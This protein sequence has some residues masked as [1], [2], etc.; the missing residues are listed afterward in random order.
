MKI[1]INYPS[2]FI[3]CFFMLLACREDDEFINTPPIATDSTLTI[4]LSG[5]V[6]KGPFING[7]AITLSEL[8]EN[9]LATGKNFTSQINDN[10]GAF[11]FKEVPLNS[12]F[13]QLQA[14][15]FYFDEVKGE[16]SSAQLTL[17]GLAH[18][19]DATSV[20]VNL[21]S[22]LEFSRVAYLMQEEESTFE[23]AKQK[24]QSEILT[25]FGIKADSI[26]YSETLDISHDGDDNAI[27][28]VISAILQAD[29]SV[30]EL[31][32]L[33]A[34]IITDL[35]EDGVVNSETTK[36][37]LKEQ[38]MS[39]NLPQI[40]THLEKRY[41]DMGVEATIPNFEQ[42]VDSDGDGILNKDEDDTPENFNFSLQKD[43]ATKVN[44]ISNVVTL[45]GLKEGGTADAIVQHGQIILNGKLMEDSV[46]QVK[47]GDQLQLQLT[48]SDA[49]AD[50]VSTKITIGTLVKNFQVITDDYIPDVFSFTAQKD[51]AVDSF[52]TSNTITVSG[53]P[54]ATPLKIEEGTIIKNGVELETDTTS[55]KNG[56]ELA[57]KLLSSTEFKAA[58]SA[59]VDINGIAASFSITTDDYSPDPFSFTPIKNAKIKRK[60]ISDT[61]TITGLPHPTPSGIAWFSTD[62]HETGAI[63]VNGVNYR[64]NGFSVK[65]GDKI[66]IEVTASEEFSSTLPSSLVIN[67]KEAFFTVTTEQNSWVAKL[68]LSVGAFD[69]RPAAF[70]ID[71][72]VY[73]GTGSADNGVTKAFY[74]YDPATNQ[75]IQRADYGGGAREEG[76]GFAIGNKG[77]IGLGTN[78]TSGNDHEF[79]GYDPNTDTWT[80]LA[81]YP[82][83]I[84]WLSIGF[85]INNKGY[86]GLGG[87]Q[88]DF[89]EYDPETDTWKQ[90]ANLPA[91][92]RYGAIAF[93]MNGKGYVGLG[94][95]DHANL[96]D[97][98]EYDPAIN[99]WKQLSDYP[100][101]LGG[102]VGFSIGNY[103]YIGNN[104]YVDHTDKVQFYQYDP[105][106]D[107]WKQMDIGNMLFSNPIG[108]STSTKGYH[109]RNIYDGV[110]D[111][112]QI[113]EFTP[114]KE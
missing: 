59:L 48:S 107:S 2:L 98:W 71:N 32:E 94:A 46:T 73:F 39:L 22:Y 96:R 106:L 75:L 30:A 20:N 43:V 29:N 65:T 27:L 16:K 109:I 100:G 81:D 113:W 61:I 45:S 85:S 12:P 41:T 24:A 104:Y 64:N 6:Q 91:E 114:P 33:L 93:S 1:F 89:W 54:F 26:G 111:E 62:D 7:T 76:I 99:S 31:S 68:S 28:L 103:A 58:T 35:K 83:K 66:W 70:S 44:I 67:D 36:T 92:G 88:N 84:S 80:K 21:L 5:Y 25:V 53:I 42:Y 74:E 47:N 3:F 10:K 18:V 82:G 19:T 34:N 51:V 87:I 108:I 90:L 13:V 23:E 57:V 101:L 78:S 17:F 50:T 40:R 52:Y 4:D 63:Y 9:L 69:G 105:I 97:L 95:G 60:Y 8:N 102:A 79:Y 49:Y 15:G 77:Y 86:V 38:A 56:D 112:S 11:N 55:V 72:K 110:A 37:K 14:N